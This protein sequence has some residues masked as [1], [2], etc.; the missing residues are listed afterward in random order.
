MMC[1]TTTKEY[2][3]PALPALSLLLFSP[4]LKV[5]VD[6]VSGSG[7]SHHPTHSLPPNELRLVRG[8]G[9]M[10]PPSPPSP[11]HDKGVRHG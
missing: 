2:L 10:L 3:S 4:S 5:G 11:A 7:C 9:V 8:V 1:L 6:E